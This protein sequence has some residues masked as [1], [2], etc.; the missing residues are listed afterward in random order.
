MDLLDLIGNTP[1]VPVRRLFA[2]YAGVEVW[3]KAEYFNPGGSI[4]DRAARSMVLAAEQ[5]GAL[6]PG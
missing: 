1:L 2:G 3:A 5:S 4:K 6:T